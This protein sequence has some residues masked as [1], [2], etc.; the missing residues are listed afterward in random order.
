MKDFRKQFGSSVPDDLQTAVE[1]AEDYARRAQGG[2]GPGKPGKQISLK[3]PAGKII[4]AIIAAVLVMMTLSGS[5][6]NVSEQQ[7]A[8]VMMFGQVVDV[9]GAGLYFKIPVIQNVI[10][11]DTTTHGM[12]IGY[13]T[14]GANKEYGSGAAYTTYEAEAIMITSDFNFVDVD[15]YLEYRVSDPVKYTFASR[16]PEEILRNIAQ[17]AIRSTVSD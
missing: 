16:R 9:R 11:V 5:F 4:G 6:Y 1:H 2:K 17:A 12:P 10:K 15:F 3:G 8:I 13:H 14:D 7:Q